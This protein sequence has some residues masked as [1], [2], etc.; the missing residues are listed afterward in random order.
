MLLVLGPL[1]MV[2]LPV[3]L[4]RWYEAAADEAD[5]DGDDAT[6]VQY[7][8]QALRWCPT[9][10]RLRIR[11]AELRLKI[12]DFPGSLADCNQALEVARGGDSV[13]AL[14]QRML[15]Y[16]RMGR[17]ADA[18]NDT[19]R[20]VQLA[21]QAPN[22][23]FQLGDG[24]VLSYPVALNY[25]AYARALAN[26][27]PEKGLDDIKQAFD[28]RGSDDDFAFLDTRGYLYYLAG[29]IKAALRDMERAVRLA[30]SALADFRGL[31]T[32]Q[33]A[34]G[35]DIK[36]LRRQ[37]ELF[38]QNLAVLYHHRGLVYQKLGR[39]QDAAQ[40]LAR[41]DELGYDPENGVW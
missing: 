19:D 40:D 26:Q 35:I 31:Q 29:D 30:E 11:R 16:Q 32:E 21:S 8:S 39:G 7:V 18:L 36:L 23:Q 25:R 10:P 14:V 28:L 27:D 13:Q 22:R 5:L 15:T 24:A 41:A 9:D 6:A 1:M 12:R 38:E 34:R 33:L 2:S 20:I 3:E 17:H 4:S 37:T